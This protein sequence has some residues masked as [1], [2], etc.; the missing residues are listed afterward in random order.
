VAPA[1]VHAVSGTK[2]AVLS[3]LIDEALASALPDASHLDAWSEIIPSSRSEGACPATGRPGVGGPSAG[4]AIRARGAEGAG[5]GEDIAGLARDLLDWRRAT[6]ARMVAVLAGEDGL[7]PG[8]TQEPCA[9]VDLEA[10]EEW[11][12]AQDVGAAHEAAMPDQRLGPHGTIGER[13]EYGGEGGAPGR[14]SAYQT[15][16]R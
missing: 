16:S 15:T 11:R 13:Y 2:R 12:N 7:R 14:S 10:L 6:A 3:T 1:T 5:A 4:G 8:L 9:S